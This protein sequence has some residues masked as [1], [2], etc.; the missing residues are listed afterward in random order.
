MAW[1]LRRYARGT[2]GSKTGTLDF[3]AMLLAATLADL[4]IEPEDEIESYNRIQYN[5]NRATEY[6]DF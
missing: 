6:A 1:R 5:F 2:K 4:G 3:S